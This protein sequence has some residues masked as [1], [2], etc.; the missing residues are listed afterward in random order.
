MVPLV[1]KRENSAPGDSA[2]AVPL[3]K[4]A[5]MQH[6]LDG[7][8]GFSARG[9]DG[10]TADCT[11]RC[12]ARQGTRAG[13]RRKGGKERSERGEMVDLTVLPAKTSLSGKACAVED[14]P[15]S[16]R[17]SEPRPLGCPPILTLPAGRPAYHPPR[18]AECQGAATLSLR[19][20]PCSMDNGAAAGWW[21]VTS[22][23]SAVTRMSRTW[24]CRWMRV[25]GSSGGIH[26]DC[27]GAGATGIYRFGATLMPTLGSPSV[28]VTV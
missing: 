27:L 19:A 12:G 3:E 5:A 23:M 10:G 18:P 4:R 25:M 16:T 7:Y 21:S 1:L 28:P 13:V 17:A 11:G 9:S 22:I 14:G 24:P 26:H 6:V 20:S 15:S 2:N 8:G